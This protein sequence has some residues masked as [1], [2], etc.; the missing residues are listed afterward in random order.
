MIRIGAISDTHLTKVT[1]DL[2]RM[3]EGLLADVDYLIHA[4]DF[5]SPEVYEYL[6][7]WNLLAVRGNMDDGELWDVLPPRRTENIGGRRIGIVHGTGSWYGIER[8]VLAE[9][10]DVD[11]IV[12]GHSHV[13]TYRK[14]GRAELF[15]PGAFT[16][17]RAQQR[18]VGIVEIDDQIAC[19]H[20][21]I[22]R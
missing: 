19:R 5:I 11:L 18:T 17:P 2:R 16:R 7:R 8:V 21:P 14:E 3:M 4:G 6:C 15:N 22:S 13:P 12:F 20:I 1:D 10:A 9:F